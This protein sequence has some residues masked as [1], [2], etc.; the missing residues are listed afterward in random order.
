MGEFEPLIAQTIRRYIIPDARIERITTAPMRDDEQGYSGARLERHA[1]TFRSSDGS[2]ETTTLITKEASL[3]ERRVLERLVA[4]RQAVPFSHT[5]D[6]TADAP[7]L[8]CQQNVGQSA[9][10]VDFLRTVACDLARAHYANLG[11]ATELE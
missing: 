3:T 9:A 11:Q 1:V 10:P 6:L 8:V 2:I 5:L 4:Q 7:K